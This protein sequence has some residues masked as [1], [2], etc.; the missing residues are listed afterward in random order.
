MTFVRVLKNG[1]A[2]MSDERL[3]EKSDKELSRAWLSCRLDREQRDLATTACSAFER[4]IARHRPLR[5]SGLA[6][7]CLWVLGAIVSDG[8]CR[9]SP[10]LVSSVTN[11]FIRIGP[12]PVQPLQSQP[13]GYQQS[14]EF[15][16]RSPLIT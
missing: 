12:K 13:L 15:G 16:R 10:L 4:I 2:A 11:G 6:H 3:G 14:E 1:R 7:S 8:L 9:F 5:W